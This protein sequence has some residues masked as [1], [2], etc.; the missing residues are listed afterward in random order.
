[1]H[2]RSSCLLGFILIFCLVGGVRAQDQHTLTGE[3]R[4]HKAFH[5]R[6]L[7]A[8]RDILVYLPPGYAKKTKERYAVLYMHDGQNLFDGATAFIKGSEWR[9]DESAQ[10][11]ISSKK[12]KPVIIV[13]IYNSGAA[14]VD[15]YTP[16]RDDAHN[17]GG[18]GDL[19]G[20]MIVEELKPLIDS[21]YRTLPDIEHTAIGGSSLG[22]LISLH[23]A[24]AHP[25]TFGI[26]AVVS[27][28]VWWDNKMIVR[29]VNALKAKPRLRVWLDIGTKEGGNKGGDENTVNDA[30]ALRDALI[31]KGW[32]QG[33]DLMYFE[34]EGAAHNERS[35]AERVPPMLKFLFP[36]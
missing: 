34:A 24:L 35:W 30:K 14:R 22:A 29:E 12:I 3:F 19:Y 28:S 2:R 25:Q 26:V 5:S 31:A 23:L 9:L 7:S 21:T 17:M 13:G 4:T 33:S 1:M 11:L 6:F 16:T 32:K 18:M 27:P 8:D 10:S 36:R 15:E 20:R